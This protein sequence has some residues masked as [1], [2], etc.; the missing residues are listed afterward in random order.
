[1]PNELVRQVL[2][3]WIDHGEMHLAPAKGG[4]LTRNQLVR[5]LVLLRADRQLLYPCP[6][7]T[8]ETLS[9]AVQVLEI[10]AAD[11]CAA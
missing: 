6:E 8:R 4:K 3:E 9:P 5:G 7:R 1:V 2:V 10:T 11:L